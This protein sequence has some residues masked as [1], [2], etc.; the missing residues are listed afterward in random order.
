MGIEKIMQKLFNERH[1]LYPSPK[2]TIV[3]KSMRDD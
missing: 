1:N 2:V 3:I